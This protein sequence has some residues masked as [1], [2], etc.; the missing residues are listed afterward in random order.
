MRTNCG[1]RLGAGRLVGA[2]RSQ[3]EEFFAELSML[4]LRSTD[5]ELFLKRMK[6]FLRRSFQVES[7]TFAIKQDGDFLLSGT[8]KTVPSPVD[9]RT[10]MAYIHRHHHYNVPLLIEDVADKALQQAAS[11][12]HIQLVLP[13]GMEGECVGMLLFG[14]RKKRY[15][16]R[17]L[18]L[19]EVV[20]G[21]LVVALK[22]ALVMA[23]V[24]KLN[25]SLQQKIIDATRELRISNQQLQRLDA[26]KDEFI[27]MASHQLRTPLTSIKGYLDMMLEGDLGPINATQRTVLKEAFGSSERMVQLIGDFLSV[28]RLQTG[29]FVV[30]RQPTDVAKLVK[31]EISFLTTMSRQRQLKVSAD[32]DTTLPQVFVDAEKLRQ[33]I[34]NMI[35]NALYYSK[36]RTTIHVR[37]ASQDDSIIFTVKDTGIGVP[38]DEQANLFSK[39]FRGSN[40]RRKR[41]DGTG[42]GLF[43]AR[44]VILA[45]EGTIIF[46]SKEGKGS[47]FG[48]RLPM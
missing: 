34:M 5:L 19:L 26:A 39:F 48:F 25:E 1:H 36:P 6:C 44:K 2:S 14:R 32:I 22:N 20:S 30:N 47:T 16:R 27:S 41:P 40:A 24:S 21:E 29:K 15:G 43:L 38:A 42:I 33:V 11:L 18:R 46:E 37:L 23:E 3:R 28:S 8:K 4:L 13:L 35:E 45:H 10:L 17:D 31:D 9:I 7:V 12:H